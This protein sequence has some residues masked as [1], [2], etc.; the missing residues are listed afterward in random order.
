[1]A[2]Q[3]KRYHQRE[4]TPVVWAPSENAR[5][6]YRDTTSLK[7]KTRTIKKNLA[8]S[9]QCDAFNELPQ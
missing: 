5:N 3:V 4:K 6:E 1:M 7:K 2:I 8:R 9:E